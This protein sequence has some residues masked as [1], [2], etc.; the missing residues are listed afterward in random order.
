M[1]EKL[2]AWTIAVS[3][4]LLFWGCT[5]ETEFRKYHDARLFELACDCLTFT[6]Q[7]D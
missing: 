7:K 6:F 4:C 1:K 3:I 2:T 5:E